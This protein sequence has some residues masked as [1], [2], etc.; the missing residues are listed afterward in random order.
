MLAALLALQGA[1]AADAGRAPAAK[2]LRY[3]FPAAETGFDP[4]QVTDLYSNTVLAHIFE[5]PLEYEYLAQPVRVR[6]NTAAAMPEVSAD[7]RRFVFTIRAGHLLRRRPG[8]SRQA[9]RADGAGLRVL[10]QAPLRPALEERQA[11]SVRDGA[12]PGPERIAARGDRQAR[13]PFDYDREVDGPARARPLSLR[14]AAGAAQPALAPSLFADPAFTGAMAREVVEYY[15]DQHRRA[16]GGHRA[17]PLSAWRRSS[18]MVLER[19]PGFREVRYD[20]HPP[21]DDA[22]ARGD[23]RARCKGRRLPMV[24]RVE[25]AVIEEPQPRWLS[26]LNDEQDIVERV[27]DEFCE[28]ALPEQQAGAATWRNA[29]SRWCAT[30]ATTSRVSYFAMENPVVGG[31]T[32]DKVALRRAISLA[33]D[34]E[35]EI[36]IARHGQA[37]PAQSHIATAGVGLRPGVQVRDERVRPRQGAR[38]ARPVR[39]RRPRRRRLARAARRLAADDRVR[40]LARRHLS[41]RCTSSGRST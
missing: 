17:V 22:A 5:A 32:P 35:R 33:V 37:I 9:A 30:S 11:L 20:E 23:R 12:D 6:P 7:Y 25:V 21:A 13:Q 41:A 15:G 16:P 29:A 27:P 10:D 40:H 18:R 31:Y 4:A 36:R 1:A 2:V 39:L 28:S 19:N 26:F 38:A 34:V 24:D 3:A 8:V 14:G